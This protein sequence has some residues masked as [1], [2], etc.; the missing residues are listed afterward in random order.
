MQFPPFAG[1]LALLGIDGPTTTR[2]YCDYF[3]RSWN[4]RHEEWMLDC[5]T[6]DVVVEDSSL[7]NT[8][9]IGKAA[10]LQLAKSQF[11]AFPDLRYE[12]VDGPFIKPGEAAAM[13]IA[14]TTG[15][16]LGPMGKLAATGRAINYLSVEVLYFRDGKV[17]RD[18]HRF[19]TRDL[20][21][22][23]GVRP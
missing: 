14:R 4:A 8:P 23:M 5:V 12:M 16:M 7:G 6:E 20:F 19:D 15:T 17:A 21:R 10:F 1:D 2:W 22:K 3:I 9:I 18:F 13:F 11:T